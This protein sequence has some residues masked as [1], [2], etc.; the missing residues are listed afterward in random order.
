MTTKD[1]LVRVAVDAMGGDNAPGDVVAGAVEAAR[2]GGVQIMLVG[3]PEPVQTELAR[4]DTE[5]LPISI[6]PSEGVLVEGRTTGLS[7]AAKASSIH[8]RSNRDG[9]AGARR[10]IRLNG[11][12]R[13]GDGG[14][15]SS[16]RTVAGG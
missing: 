3:D 10:R 15:G 6:I 8:F 1:T 5:Q 13:R 14:G 11:F 4:Y 7:V 2:H 16:S 12:D 9:E